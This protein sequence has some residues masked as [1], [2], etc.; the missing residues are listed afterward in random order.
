MLMGSSAEPTLFASPNVVA[1]PV[2]DG[3]LL[4]RSAEPLGEHP[5]TVIHSLRAGPARTQATCS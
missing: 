3:C 5:V 1:D 2:G 4:L